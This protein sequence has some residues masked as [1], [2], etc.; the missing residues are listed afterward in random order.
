MVIRE[1]D[2][3]SFKPAGDGGEEGKL[4]V[5]AYK[6]NS[7]IIRIFPA[8]SEILLL[9]TKYRTQTHTRYTVQ[10]FSQCGGDWQMQSAVFVASSI[11]GMLNHVAGGVDS[12]F[13]Q[14]K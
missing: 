12:P 13:I 2:K 11:H 10:D 3:C 8:R 5:G 6:C 7:N 4:T 14:L 1:L 9:S